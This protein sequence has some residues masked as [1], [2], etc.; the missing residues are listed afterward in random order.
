MNRKL[1]LIFSFIACIAW[2]PISAQLTIGGTAPVYDKLTGTYMLTVAEDV[3]GHSYH[4]SVILDDGVTDVMIDGKA[5]TT[6]VDFPVIQGDTCYS[7]VFK[8][9]NVLNQSTIHFTFLPILCITGNFTDDYVVA[10]V[11]MTLPDGQGVQHYSARI[12]KAG[13]STNTQWV[14][15]HNYHVKFVDQDG[16]KTDVSFF[17]LRNDN[18]WRLDAGTRDMIRFR[19]YAANALWADFATKPYYADQQPKA[20]S[21][22]RGSHVEMFLNGNYNGFYNLSEFL[23]R[24]QLKL[25][26]YV[27]H[28]DPDGEDNELLSAVDFHG[29]MWKTSYASPITL[30]SAYNDYSNDNS[31]SWNGFSLE[32]PDID[33]VCPTDYS[34]IKNAVKFVARSDDDTFNAQV[35]DYFDLPVLVDYYLFLNL[36]FAIDNAGSNMVYACYDGAV[37]KKLTLAVWDL[38]ATVGQ[39]FSDNEGYYHAPEI[40]PE[41]ELDDV[42]TTMSKFSINR[43]LQRV[44]QVPGFYQQVVKRYWQ[45]RSGVLDPDSLVSRYEAIYRRLDAAGAINR[46]TVRWSDTGDI[47]HRMLDFPAEFDYL[48]DWITR[49]IAHLDACTFAS[50]KGDVNGDGLVNISDVIQLIAIVLD[51]NIVPN[52]IACDVNSDDGV[53]VADVVSLINILLLE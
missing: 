11:D 16:E 26:K 23:D 20:R 30:F 10:P 1:T 50:R 41:C 35:G 19:N 27:E 29:M 21:Y 18:H 38:D 48:C 9:N 32:Y 47:S 36:V 17:G 49:R 40:Q 42:P 31:D 8:K 15:K 33:D 4:A 2:L 13:A 24:K 3:F 44:K 53:N 5:V 39:N 51:N 28:E 45:L 22:I 12:K 7:F 34:I 14:H 6:D 25:K 46:E 37:D 43:L 52:V